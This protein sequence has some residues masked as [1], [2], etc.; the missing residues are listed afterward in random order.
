[1]CLGY[2][3]IMEWEKILQQGILCRYDG[4]RGGDEI[5]ELVDLKHE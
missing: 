1:M 4:R 5:L 3:E 2:F